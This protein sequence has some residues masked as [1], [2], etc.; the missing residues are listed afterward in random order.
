MQAVDAWLLH[1]ICQGVRPGKIVSNF[2]IKM[3][4]TFF[5]LLH[6]KRQQRVFLQNLA[7]LK[8]QQEAKAIHDIRVAIKKLRSYL[9]LLA[10]LLN[11]TD[12]TPGFEKTEQLFS[13]LGKYRDIEMGLLLLQ[14]F[15]KENKITYTAF[16]FQLKLALQTTET[17]AQNALN[18]YDEKELADLTRELG[19]DLKEK[20]KN[21]LS[22]KAGIVLNKE[23]KKLKRVVKHF[24]N[25]PHEVRKM[26]KNIF[27]WISICPK[28]FLFNSSQVI[29]LRKSLGYLGDWQ[30]HEMLHQK[31]KHFRKDFVPDSREEYLLLKELEKNIESR[32]EVMLHKADEIVQGFISI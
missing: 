1:S 20:D 24:S 14:S 15:E 6:W 22:G 25:Q 5:I 11:K 2:E 32:M 13:V 7:K 9:K 4:A 17:W 29:K 3:A 31:I 10:I 27:Y 23:F 12:N 19:Q 26:L 28:D 18:K 16:R 8:G 21:D 30:D